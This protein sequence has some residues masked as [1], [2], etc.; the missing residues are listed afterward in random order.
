MYFSIIIPIYNVDK[1]LRECVDSILAQS[2]TD[3]ELILVNDG[4]TD[5]SSEICDEYAKKDKRITV[6]HKEN[7]GLSD[8]RNVGTG[9]AKGKYIIYIDSDDFVISWDFLLDVYNKTQENKVDLVLYKFQKYYQTTGLSKC[10]FSLDFKNST[11]DI[12]QTLLSCVTSDAYYGMAWIKAIKRTLI[13]E[14][15]IKFEK[16]LLGEDMDWYFHILFKAKTIDCIDESYI[17]YR[18]REG[19]I[20]ATNKLKNLTDFIYILEKWYSN[21]L[22]TELDETHKKA[23]LG[24]M[25]KY[26][27]NLLIT[28]S[29]VKDKNKKDFKSRMKKLSVLLK[30][31]QSSRPKTVKKIYSVLGFSGVILMLKILDKTKGR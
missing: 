8:A 26:Y 17:A 20:S 31:S 15:N 30:F 6:I 16:G 12:G 25:A 5:T 28:Y 27:S 21:I 23:L 3:Y 7:G 14:N 13:E 19:S 11:Q 29:R 22:Q 10:T 1:Y 18:Q 9:E 4:S 24:A 2:F